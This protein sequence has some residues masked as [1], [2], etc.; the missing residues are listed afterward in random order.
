M[1]K[2]SII[3]VLV[4]LIGHLWE[5]ELTYRYIFAPKFTLR[6]QQPNIVP[7]IG[8]RYRWLRWANLP[9]VSTT[10]AR[11]V[12]K[13]AAGVVDPGVVDT[14][15]NNASETGDKICR[16]CCWHQCCWYGWCTLTCKYL[17]EF[18]K[19]IETVLMGYSGAGGKLVHDKNQKQKSR[20]AVTLME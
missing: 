15:I 14:G 3:N 17:Q 13:F 8:R 2:T 11:L 10:L 12:A 1:E 7:I 19:K 9:P 5:V 20:D 16:R 6:F 4:I 18:S